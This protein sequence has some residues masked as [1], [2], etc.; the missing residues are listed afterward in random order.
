MILSLLQ[1]M[2]WCRFF[3]LRYCVCTVPKCMDEGLRNGMKNI[4]LKVLAK[5]N[6]AIR[7]YE[8]FDFHIVKNDDSLI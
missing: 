6:K 8:K 1:S 5:N 4:E 3:V 2:Y 7:L